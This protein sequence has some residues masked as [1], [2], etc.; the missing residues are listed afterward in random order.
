[1]ARN[2]VKALWKLAFLDRETERPVRKRLAAQREV[3]PFSGVVPKISKA[4]QLDKFLAHLLRLLSHNLSI[5]A[6]CRVETIEGRTEVRGAA[7]ASRANC[8]LFPGFGNIQKIQGNIH[9]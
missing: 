5:G 3:P 8:L 6:A 4:H 9:G 1:M 7:V 2:G